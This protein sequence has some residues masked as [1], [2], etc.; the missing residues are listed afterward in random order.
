MTVPEGESVLEELEYLNIRGDAR[1]P[2][3]RREA[4]LAAVTQIT[5]D[6]KAARG[7]LLADKPLPTSPAGCWSGSLW[8]SR[9]GTAA[10]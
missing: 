10:S 3:Q 2:Q 4:F 5:G 8:A 7:A 6:V 1:V 9:S